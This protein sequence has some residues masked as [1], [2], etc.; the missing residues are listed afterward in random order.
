MYCRGECVLPA[1]RSPEGAVQGFFPRDEQRQPAHED[2]QP[3]DAPQ[4]QELE[5]GCIGEP[6]VQLVLQEL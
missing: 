6:L 4:E 2:E 1:S 5:A 3:G